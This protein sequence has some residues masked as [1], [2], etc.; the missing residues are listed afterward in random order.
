MAKKIG[1]WDLPPQMH[2]FFERFHTLH[3]GL[4]VGP[5]WA[6]T[7]LTAQIG[8]AS[9][10]PTKIGNHVLLFLYSAVYA[11]VL[12]TLNPITV[13][14]RSPLYVYKLATN[15]TCVIMFYMIDCLW[16]YRFIY[17]AVDLSGHLDVRVWYG[18]VINSP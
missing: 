5:S 9:R 1:E 15:M 7:S 14:G 13:V 18:I 16:F 6:E 8:R 4:F 12:I 2:K 11:Q 10:F 3:Q 17:F